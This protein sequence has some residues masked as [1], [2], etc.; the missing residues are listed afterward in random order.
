M[1]RSLPVGIALLGLV[2]VVACGGDP[3]TALPGPSRP[4]VILVVVDALRAD[5]LG[6]YGSDRNLTPHI[7][8]LAARSALFERAYSNGTFTYPSTASLFTSTL[9]PVH[10][11]THNPKRQAQLRAMSDGYQLITESFHDAGYRTGLLTTTGWVTPTANYMQG[12][13]ERIESARSD[14]DLLAEAKAFITRDSDR[15]FF[16]YLHFVDMHDYFMPRHLFAGATEADLARL[17]PALLATRDATPREAYRKLAHELPAVATPADLEFLQAAYGR[18]LRETD[19]IIGQLE[20][21]IAAAGLCDQTVLA[22]TAD[23]GE[24]FLEHDRLVHGGDGFYNEV[25]HIPL[26]IAGVP[27]ELRG[28]RNGTPVSSID[29]APTLLALVGLP[30]APEY[31]GDNV[32]RLDDPARIVFATDVWTWKAIDTDWSLIRSRKFDRLEL[33]DLRQDPG[34]TTNLAVSQSAELARMSTAIEAMQARCR[35]HPY[36][37]LS[38]DE[39]EMPQ[40]QQERLRALGYLD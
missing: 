20:D 16:L 3:R 31:Q 6:C 15:P 32:L 23:H 18:G 17:S 35:E 13:D 19:A 4:N 38:V 5:M 30:A 7:D 8:T 9:Q 12:V 29:I 25:L 11:I 10:R 21:A 24:Q 28:T 36:M 2:T 37:S 40:D 14:L 34:E 22:L 27:A 26:V 33:Y 39:V 1:R